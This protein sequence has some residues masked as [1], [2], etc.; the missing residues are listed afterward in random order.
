MVNFV[1]FLFV[2]LFADTSGQI[3]TGG[4]VTDQNGK[5]V[6]YHQEEASKLDDKQH[7][8]SYISKFFET[9]ASTLAADGQE[10][11]T[12]AGKTTLKRHAT[13]GNYIAGDVNYK[14]V[15]EKVGEG[16]RYWFTDLSYQP[17]IKDRYGKIVPAKVK[18]IPLEKNMT[19]VNQGSWNKQR[20]YAYQTISNL[21]EHFNEYLNRGDQPTVVNIPQ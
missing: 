17:Y 7:I 8:E 20:E 2:G 14:L 1:M 3:N 18:P 4:F 21:A 10:R 16:Y 13:I 9:N 15:F 5:Y 6:V 11:V 12:V 19:R